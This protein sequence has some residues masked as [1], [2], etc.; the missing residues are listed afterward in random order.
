MRINQT[1]V[2]GDWSSPS[3]LLLLP[4]LPLLLLSSAPSVPSSTWTRTSHRAHTG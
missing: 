1:S 2:A 4:L 3:L